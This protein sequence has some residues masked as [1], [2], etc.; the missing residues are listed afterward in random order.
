[1]LAS[2]PF[3]VA[4]LLSFGGDADAPGGRSLV[5]GD[6]SAGWTVASFARAADAL[7]FARAIPEASRVRAHA[8]NVARLEKAVAAS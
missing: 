3:A 7:A 4:Y 5:M 6:G 8:R 2:H 1:M